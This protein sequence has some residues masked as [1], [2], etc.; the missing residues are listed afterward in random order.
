[1]VARLTGGGL[2]MLHEPWRA[3]LDLA[4]HRN[5]RSPQSRFVQLA[6]V[7]PDGRPAVRTVVFRGFLGESGSAVF[8]TDARS[9]KCAEIRLRPD[10]ELCWYFPETREQFRLSGVARLV[11]ESTAAP[12]LLATRARTWRE[13]S[14]AARVSFTWPAP[15]APRPPGIAFPE[16]PPDA[17][18]PPGAFALI[19]F[20][21]S[22]VD[23]LE[24]DGDP[25]HRWSY[26][27]DEK[28]AW[29]GREVNP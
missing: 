28:G 23:F 2:I 15:G 10:A 20:S 16:M 17:E 4:L 13:L 3:S 29:S 5:R 12:D 11:D 14:D 1:V 27:V 26:S 8:T 21:A 7:R 22:R 24:L 18:A 19:V 6:T 25:Q 9:A